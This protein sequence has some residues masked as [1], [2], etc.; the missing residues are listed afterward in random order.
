MFHMNRLPF[1]DV[2]PVVIACRFIRTDLLI[3]DG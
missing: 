2:L 1:A 3:Y